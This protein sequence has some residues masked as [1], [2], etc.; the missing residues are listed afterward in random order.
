MANLTCPAC[1]AAIADNPRRASAS[2]RQNEAKR[3]RT[4]V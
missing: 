1:G 3:V 4:R 2:L